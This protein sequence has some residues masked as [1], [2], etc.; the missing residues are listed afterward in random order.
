V[1]LAA[2]CG[3][4]GGRLRRKVVSTNGALPLLVKHRCKVL[5]EE[6]SNWRRRYRAGCNGVATCFVY[7]QETGGMTMSS[8]AAVVE[9][10]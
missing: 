4:D 3:A 1:T 8:Y 2:E 9:T 7:A 6:L 10:I 5:N